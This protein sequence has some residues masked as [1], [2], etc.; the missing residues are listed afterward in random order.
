MRIKK[1]LVALA[2]L[3]CTAALALA[4]C[5]GQSDGYKIGIAQ[6]MSHPSLDAAVAGF[7]Q[8]L[9]DSG[10]E[11]T[12]D[13]QNAQGDQGTA[14]AVAQ[15]FAGAHL[16]LALAVATPM[17]QVMAQNIT[18]VPVLFTAVTDAEA[19]DLV[20]T[21]EKPGANVTG[22]SDMN[23]VP[24]QI[25]LIKQIMPEAKQVGVIYSAAEVNS[26]V[27]VDAA[28][29]A[30][31][32]QGLK[33]VEKKITNSSEVVQAAQTLT[34]VDAIYIP[35]DNMV[36]SALDSVL[37][38]AWEKQILVV[39]GDVNCVANGAALTYG[40]DYQKLGYQTGEMAVKILQGE[41]DPAST[42]VE[43]QENPQLVVNPA[44]AAKMGHPLPQ[45]LLDKADQTI[46]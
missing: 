43:F 38:V 32:E 35:T 37:Q 9:E 12:F 20:T 17:A 14:A 39:S 42:P 45:E 24:Q 31:K 30:A 19:A 25:A 29:K 36:V 8:A 10:L 34:G 11:V 28:K 15:K 6:L 13:E 4:G 22:T 27:Q 21:N 44:A 7:K 5:S 16:D 2:A 33:I 40:L 18:D 23:P 1:K 41:A 26:Q 3:L 46:K